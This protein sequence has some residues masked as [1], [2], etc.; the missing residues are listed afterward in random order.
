MTDNMRGILAILAASTAFVLN[1][2]LVKLVTAELPTGQLIAIRGAMATTLILAVAAAMRALARPRVLL[3]WPMAVRVTAASVSTLFIVLSLK[4]MPLAI[5]TSVLQ[6][7]PVIVTVGSAL[8]FKEE[9]GWR[10]WATTIAGFAGVLLIVQPGAA[11]LDAYALF[12]LAA[13]LFT[14]TRDLTTRLIDK[15]VSSLFVAGASSGL[16]TLVGCA[17]YG[18]E[19]WVV[20]S[21]RA[22]VL[23]ALASVCLLFAYTLIIYAMRT[24]Q[25]SV[26]APFRY[27]LIPL[28]LLLGYL[29]WGDVPN[30]LAWVGIAIVI[31]SGLY[32]LR[33]E[34]QS[35]RAAMPAALPSERP[36][37]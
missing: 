15:S 32:A 24:G 5:V 6:V 3:A 36:A 22:L 1:D 10:R 8:L 14:T 23:L 20:P 17:F 35:S 11:G 30:A 2:T 25:L 12:A 27:T 18:L 21:P 29:I 26:V 9:V 34:R 31:G 4:H 7:T 16:I 37:P 33:S 28:S 13:L 19:R